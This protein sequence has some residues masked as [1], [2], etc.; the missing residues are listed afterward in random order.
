MQSQ[1]SV[2]ATVHHGWD[3]YFDNAASYYMTYD[4]S[5]FKDPHSLTKCRRPQDDITLADG[6]VILPDGIGTV[7]L[8]FS[9]KDSAERI[10]LS[11][12]R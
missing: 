11:V 7:S 9:I 1:G 4:L 5:D 10:I 8:V 3:W 2:L 12:V 6:S